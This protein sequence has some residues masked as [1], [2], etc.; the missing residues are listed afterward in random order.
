MIFFSCFV[1]RQLIYFG[2]RRSENNLASMD[3]VQSSNNFPSPTTTISEIAQFPA[4]K[5]SISRAYASASDCIKLADKR[6]NN[7]HTVDGSFNETKANRLGDV[8]ST[9]S[10]DVRRRLFLRLRLFYD[11]FSGGVAPFLTTKWEFYI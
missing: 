11:V 9:F 5:F 4:V 3:P 7:T 8:S 1:F 6:N 2:C 10:L